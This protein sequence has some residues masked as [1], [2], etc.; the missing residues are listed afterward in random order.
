VRKIKGG[1]GKYKEREDSDDDK[2]SL[3]ITMETKHVNEKNEYDQK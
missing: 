1:P 3:S 2:E